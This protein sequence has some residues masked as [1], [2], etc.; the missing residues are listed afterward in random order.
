[1]FVFVVEAGVA[2][3]DGVFAVASDEEGIG[4]SAQRVMPGTH[5]L[6]CGEQKERLH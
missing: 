2:E 1:M 6:S 5:R 4:G 3:G